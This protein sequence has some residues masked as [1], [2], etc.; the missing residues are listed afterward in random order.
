[1][2]ASLSVPTGPQEKVSDSLRLFNALARRA[3]KRQHGV[4]KDKS[5]GFIK[6]FLG[7][8]WRESF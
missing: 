7:E 8:R 3:A 5:N 2:L 1:M 4:H 6:M